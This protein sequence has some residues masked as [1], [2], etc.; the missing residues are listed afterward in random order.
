MKILVGEFVSETNENIPQRCR[1][2][3]YVIAFDDQCIQN[4]NIS[5]VYES[6]NAEMIPTIYANGASGGLA[7]IQPVRKLI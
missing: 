4:L 3:N 6:E 2:N 1:I 5:E 7:D